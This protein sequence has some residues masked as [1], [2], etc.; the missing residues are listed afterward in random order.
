MAQRLCLHRLLGALC[1][2]CDRDHPQ[3]IWTGDYG[4]GGLFYPAR[5]GGA[6]DPGPERDQGQGAQKGTV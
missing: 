2:R 3:R 5:P 6:V 1:D 4:A